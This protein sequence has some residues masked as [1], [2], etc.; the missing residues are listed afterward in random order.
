MVRQPAKVT[1]PTAEGVIPRPRLFRALDRVAGRGG[2]LWLSGQPGAGK[3]TLVA[4]WI[5]ARRRR[6][7]WLRVDAGDADLAT[8][9]HYVEVAARAATRR[10]IAL[11]AF[12]PE[13]RDRLDLFARHA[14]RALYAAL[15]RG[16]V[17]VLDDCHEV[18]ADAPLGKAWCAAIEELDPGITLVLASRSAPPPALARLRANGGLALLGGRDL[19]VTRAEALAVARAQRFHGAAGDVEALRRSVDGWAAGLVLALAAAGDGAAGA[20]GRVATFDYFAGEVFERAEPATRRVLLEAALLDAP[21]GELVAEVTGDRAA[22]RLLGALARRGLFTVRHESAP[23]AFEFHALFREF[24]LARGREELPPGRADAVRRAAAAALAPRG[25]ADAEAAISLLQEAGAHADAAT[26]VAREAPGALG[27]GRRDTVLRWV[28]G[29]SPAVRDADPWIRCWHGSALAP[30]DPAAARRLLEPALAAFEARGDAA[31]VWLSWTALVESILLE[32]SDFTALRP[33]IA[34]LERLRGRYPFPSRDVEVRATLVVAAVVAHLAPEYPHLAPWAERALALALEPG[35]ARVRLVAGAYFVQYRA[36]WFGDVEGA[37]PVVAAVGPL[38]RGA[39]V[40][41]AASIL[42]L[43]IEATFHAAADHGGAARECAAEARQRA[44]SSGVHVWDVVLHVH[45]IWTALG[46]DDVRAARVATA[47]LAACERPGNPMDRALVGSF[48]AMVALR[49]GDDAGAEG[50]AAEAVELARRTGYPAARVVGELVRSRAL[51]R[52]RR[53][54]AAWAALGAVRACVAG[55][56]TGCFEHVLALVEAERHVR[57][58]DEHAADEAMAR[59]LASARAGT[60]HA[61]YFFSGEDLARVVAEALRRGLEVERA[62][63]LIRARR[64]C[65]PPG[66]GAEWPRDLNVRAL[67]GFDVTRGG[68]PLDGGPRAPRRPLALLRALVALGGRD[69]PEERLA[70][71]LWPDSEG[72]AAHHAL[73]TALYRLRRLVGQGAVVQQGRRLSISAERC[74]VDALELEARLVASLAALQARRGAAAPSAA[75]AARI[76]DLY[77]GPLLAGDEA[78]WAEEAREAL[79]CKLTRWLRALE[80]LPGD[81]AE[82][83]RLRAELAARDAALERGVLLRLA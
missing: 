48:E 22:G 30:R 8:F 17:V 19:H 53:D 70:E 27:A 79:R 50:T 34:E 83:A 59:A 67:G 21:T 76:V 65:P 61:R 35:D 37:R 32:W 31:G 47:R 33:R 78:P 52:A 14:F 20:E 26:V 1:R 3:T 72:D 6:A 58:G 16:T 24:L 11:P 57:G 73:E 64:L 23:A 2:A 74:W 63:E 54:E 40:D 80:A 69:V 18:P 15:P 60:A 45:E 9:L 28:E 55:L 68:L 10:R 75:E 13:H 38:A 5:A 71:A 46:A 29:L 81:P 51:A 44:E 43:T 82:A 39:A 12:G 66:A 7:L 49:A 77:A 62:R 42:W 56:A 41:P 25:G 4:S 36:W